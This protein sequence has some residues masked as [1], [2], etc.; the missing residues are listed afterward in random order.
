MFLQINRRTSLF[1]ERRQKAFMQRH[2]DRPLILLV[3]LF[4]SVTCVYW[5]LPSEALGTKGP[6]FNGKLTRILVLIPESANLVFKDH[7]N[8]I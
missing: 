7:E 8:N 4:L 6:L 1:I 5:S 3:L 2:S